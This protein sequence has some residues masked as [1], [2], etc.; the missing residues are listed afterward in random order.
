[1]DPWTLLA[2]SESRS[3]G[4]VGDLVPR[5]IDTCVGDIGDL[6]PSPWH[7]CVVEPSPP[8]LY[9]VCSFTFSPHHIGTPS[10][11]SRRHSCAVLQGVRLPGTASTSDEAALCLFK[12]IF[13]CEL[14]CS[15]AVY[16]EADAVA[17]AEET[18]MLCRKSGNAADAHE[19]PLQQ[20]DVLPSGS[21]IRLQEYATVAKQRGI[22]VEDASV[23]IVNLMQ[24]AAHVSSVDTVVAPALLRTS[25]LWCM[26][27]GR[28]LLKSPEHFYIM[29]YPVPSAK[30]PPSLS[31]F[32]PFDGVE[33]TERDVKVLCGNAMQLSAIGSVMMMVF[34]LPPAED[35]MAGES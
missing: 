7:T 2:D 11:R 25:E 26:R 3:V 23:A 18:E 35:A 20:E 5:E 9:D 17:I 16:C 34:A 29:G 14:S 21:W 15:A 24:K 28:M 30:V 27:R 19:P 6:V 31:R 33:L 10:R 22:V 1:M 13:T 4:D 8:A 12:N 32:Y